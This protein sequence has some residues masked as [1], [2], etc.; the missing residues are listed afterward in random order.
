MPTP[1][2]RSSFTTWK[3]WP[4]EWWHL[5]NHPRRASSISPSLTSTKGRSSSSTRVRTSDGCSCDSWG[6]NNDSMYTWMVHFLKRKYKCIK[7]ICIPSGEESGGFSFTVTDGQH[8]TPLYRFVVTARPLTI[9]MVT[10]EELVVFPGKAHISCRLY[11]I[12]TW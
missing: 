3:L 1:P 8:T 7:H 2:R 12:Y 6:N 5:K 4:V 11:F 10:Q 9:T